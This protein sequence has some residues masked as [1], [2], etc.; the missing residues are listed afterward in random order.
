MSVP[1]DCWDHPD[2]P[3]PKPLE[4]PAVPWPGRQLP[5]GLLLFTA[6]LEKVAEATPS[7]GAGGA[8]PMAGPGPGLPPLRSDTSGR[9]KWRVLVKTPFVSHFIVYLSVNSHINRPA[10]K[11]RY[12]PS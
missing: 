12:E 2:A 9:E 3:K 11:P 6:P 7:S 10:Q 4:P 5:R 8:G 1:R